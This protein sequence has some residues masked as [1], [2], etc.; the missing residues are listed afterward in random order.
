[1]KPSIQLKSISKTYQNLTI[2]SH[3]N[4]NIDIGNYV[5]KGANGVGKST[6]IKLI[7]GLES[8]NAGEILINNIPMSKNRL[9]INQCRTFVPDH[10][11]FYENAKVEEIVA[12]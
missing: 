1:M 4:L 2:F 9:L 11:D 8:A 6:L 12:V 7:C 3:L 10:P 5:L